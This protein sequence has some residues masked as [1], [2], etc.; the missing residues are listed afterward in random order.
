M[1]RCSTPGGECSTGPRER[2]PFAGRV[3]REETLLSARDRSDLVQERPGQSVLAHRAQVGAVVR[4]SA[5]QGGDALASTGK[6]LAG[7]VGSGG[8]VAGQVEDAL[9][10]VARAD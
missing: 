4:V 1:T 6:G 8:L 9:G 10:R 3:Y 5:H 7:A 2:G